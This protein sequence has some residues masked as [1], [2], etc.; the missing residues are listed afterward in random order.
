MQ[1]L[2]CALASL[3]NP[4]DPAQP[5]CVVEN[6]ADTHESPASSGEA[7]F[8]AAQRRLGLLPDSLVAIQCTYFAGLYEKFAVRPLRAWHLLQ[9]ACVRFQA[10]LYAKALSS[11]AAG[12]EEQRARHIEQRL[13][14]SCVKAEW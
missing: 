6:D 5:A 2:A 7:F 13:Y 1:L 4:Y 12:P 8:G 9:A 14:W 10:L 11:D 3:A